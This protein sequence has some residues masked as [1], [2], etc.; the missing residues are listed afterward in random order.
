M[1]FIHLIFHCT[2]FNLKID[3]SEEV[4][5]YVLCGICPVSLSAPGLSYYEEE[6]MIKSR[7][8]DWIVGAPINGFIYPAFIDRGPDVNSIIYY[9]K[10]AKDPHPEL[11]ENTLGCSP[12]DTSAIQKEKFQYIVKDSIVADEDETDELYMKIQENLNNIVEEHKSSADDIHDEPIKLTKDE[13]QNILIESGVS[14]EYTS[15]IEKYYEEEFTEEVPLVENLIDGKALMVN[16]IRKKERNLEKQVEFLKDKLEQ[17]NPE[18]KDYDIIVHVKPEK[19]NQVKTQVIDGQ[20]YLVIPIEGNE[21][22]MI[23]EIK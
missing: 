22:S 2:E 1:I 23:Q 17:L 16:E 13:L 10:N 6:N 7:M 15:I 11:M 8:R 19:V 5:E 18:N 14:E 20:E 9:T 4:F 12:K 3:E 21:N